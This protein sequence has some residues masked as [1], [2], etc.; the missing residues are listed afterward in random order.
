MENSK[1]TKP[2]GMGPKRMGKVDK[3]K[4]FK[5][6]LKRIIKYIG[7]YNVAIITVIFVLILST[8]LSVISPKILGKATTELANNVMQK[9]VFSQINPLVSKIPEQIKEILPEDAT[10]NDLLDMNII[11]DEIKDKIPDVAKDV[12]LFNEPK[13]NYEYIFKILILILGLYLISAIFM[14]VIN[15]AM[16]YI[17]QK[18]TYGLRKEVDEKLDRLPLKFFD[19]HTHGEILSRVTNDIDTL[20][21]MLQ[22]SLV[23]ILQSVFSVIGILVMMLSIS[24]SMSG[25]AVLIIPVSLVIVATIIKNTQKYFIRQQRI[26]GKINGHVEETY[27]GALVIKAFNI[28]S[29]CNSNSNVFSSSKTISNSSCICYTSFSV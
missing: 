19:K 1:R 7:K 13:I 25:V 24:F 22:Q 29:F 26:I 10:V 12:S 20:S 21:M 23:Q 27:S 5:G 14:Y 3:P 2:A 16:A 6:T 15:R 8:I 18:V 9:M 4:D 17:S 11:P 28:S